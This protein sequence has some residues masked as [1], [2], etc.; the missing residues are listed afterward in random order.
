MILAF[1]KVC[2][3]LVDYLD[4]EVVQPCTGVLSNSV[5]CCSA[6]RLLHAAVLKQACIIGTYTVCELTT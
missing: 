4:P 5:E 3:P 6:V 2:L 1:T